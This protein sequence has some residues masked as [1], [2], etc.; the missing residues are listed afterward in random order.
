M[1]RRREPGTMRAALTSVGPRGKAS[2]LLL[3]RVTISGYHAEVPCL[4]SYNRILDPPR[5]ERG[6]EVSYVKGRIEEGL[7]QEW[8]HS[9][10][11]SSRCQVLFDT[12]LIDHWWGVERSPSLASKKTRMGHPL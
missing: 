4:D 10:P 8:D 12:I 1:L 2:L 3:L 9:V 7:G 5:L 11:S 6:Y